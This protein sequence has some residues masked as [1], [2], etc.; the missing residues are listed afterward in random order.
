MIGHH[1]AAGSQPAN[2]HNTVLK[3]AGHANIFCVDIASISQ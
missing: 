1:Q 3:P 2:S